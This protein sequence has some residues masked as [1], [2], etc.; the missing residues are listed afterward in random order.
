MIRRRR[1]LQSSGPKPTGA[2]RPKRDDVTSALLQRH[3]RACRVWHAHVWMGLDTSR[4][5]A[6]LVGEYDDFALVARPFELV[7]TLLPPSRPR[8]V[9]TGNAPSSSH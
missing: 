4:H 9:L 2:K 6:V 5:S 7:R 1:C 3:F 8:L